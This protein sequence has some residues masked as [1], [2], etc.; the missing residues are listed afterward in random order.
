MVRYDAGSRF[1]EHP[2]PDGEEILVLD[3]VF[4]DEHGD[5]PA[6]SFLLNPEGFVHAPF[7]REGCVLFVKL[8]QYPGKDRHH[9]VVDMTTA[10]W[11]EGSSPGIDV[12]EL[13]GDPGYP[14]HIAHVRI[15]PGTAGADH[16]HPAGEEIFVLEGGYRDEF[17]DYDTGSWVRYPPGSR[18][19]VTTDQGCRLYVKTGHLVDG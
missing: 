1:H 2:H 18:H 4:S 6:G 8:R 19:G 13:Y 14:E 7:S 3:G 17:G 5:Y 16:A 12:Q 10:P 11:R 9:V 15:A